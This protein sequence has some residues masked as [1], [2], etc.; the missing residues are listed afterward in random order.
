LNQST[1]LCSSVAKREKSPEEFLISAN[2]LFS[3]RVMA[4]MPSMLPDTSPLV[5]G[6][7]FAAT[8]IRFTMSETFC[9]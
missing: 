1:M 9:T 2:E 6:C 8:A 5:Q 4:L 7:S 3:S